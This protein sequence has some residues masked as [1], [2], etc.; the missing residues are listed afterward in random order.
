MSVN[1]STYVGP[2]V[3]FDVKRYTTWQ[4]EIKPA[5]MNKGCLLY[6]QEKRGKFCIECGKAMGSYEHHE[7]RNG[8][9]WKALD[10]ISDV[11]RVYPNIAN[12]VHY[13]F[14]EVGRKCSIDA[15]RA[16]GLVLDLT[17][18]NPQEEITAIQNTYVEEIKKLIDFYGSEPQFMWGAFNSIG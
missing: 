7:E 2:I 10:V 6:R 9:D 11:T 8:M 15:K 17:K 3:V 18:I 14:F 16:E 4:V 12:G 1:Y 5:C 13:W